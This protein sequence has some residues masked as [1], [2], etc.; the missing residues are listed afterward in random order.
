[1]CLGGSRNKADLGNP[2]KWGLADLKQFGALL[3]QYQ[4]D[5]Q[6]LEV[7]RDREK[8]ALK[9]IKSNILKGAQLF[10][11][12]S[13]SEPMSLVAGTRREEIARFNKAKDDKEFAKMLKART[14]G[15]EHSET[16]TQLRKSIRVSTVFFLTTRLFDI[17]LDN[18]RSSS[19]A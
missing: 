13:V 17:S 19:K 14:L 12:S 8:Q 15:P 2:A 6:S 1:M 3:L 18:T 11:F 9:E 16:Q 5:L 7:D 10:I 4:S